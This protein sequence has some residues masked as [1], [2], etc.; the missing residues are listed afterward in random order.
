MPNTAI[1]FIGFLAIAW[2]YYCIIYIGFLHPVAQDG[3]QAFREFVKLSIPALSGTLATF[4]GM[5]LCL[6]PLETLNGVPAVTMFGW[7]AC[8]A[9]VVSLILAVY[10]W[11]KNGDRTDPV[12]IGLAKLLLGLFGGALAVALNVTAK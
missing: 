6:K 11:S 2:Y 4:V 1:L 5:V 10:A 12:I 9:Y 3:S 8:L 7:A